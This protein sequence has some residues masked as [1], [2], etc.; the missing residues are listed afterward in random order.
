MKENKDQTKLKLT[1]D[2]D[3]IIKI[4][5]SYIYDIIIPKFQDYIETCKGERYFK[6]GEKIDI[7]KPLKEI[8]KEN[9]SSFQ[10]AENE[11]FIDNQILI[12]YITY[13]KYKGKEINMHNYEKF[14][15]NKDSNAKNI[16]Q[17]LIEFY[18]TK[19]CKIYIDNTI[20]KTT[21]YQLQRYYFNEN[22]MKKK[23]RIHLDIDNKFLNDEKKVKYI[24]EKIVTKISDLTKIPQ[25]E[26]YVTNVRKNCLIFDIYHRIR[27][28][29]G[30]ILRYFVGDI[31]NN[32]IE[33]NQD[34]LKI[35]FNQIYQ[36]IGNEINEIR[37]EDQIQLNRLIKIEGVINNYIKN[38]ELE[39]DSRFNKPIGKFGYRYRFI[40]PDWYEKKK[41]KNGKNYYYPNKKW[42]G[43][44]LR[45]LFKKAYDYIFFPEQIFDSKGNWCICYTDLAFS[46]LSYKIDYLRKDTFSIPSNDTFQRF[47]LLY[48]CKI[49]K[50]AIFEENENVITSY[51][52][53]FLMP[54]R[55]LIENIDANLE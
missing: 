29:V 21:Y 8:I 55:L 40:L 52:E 9:I 25:N 37:D 24:V 45:I 39:F 26:L 3:E 20:D 19:N 33:K 5:S 10:T 46:K 42:E 30:R 15:S 43:Y 41:L 53:H 51:D 35:F 27:K 32:F 31:N 44:G 38:I 13:E 50:Y 7:N 54:Y 49:N 11:E 47:S 14:C 6:V 22:A 23:I 4:I 36:E 17:K 12:D 48:Q 18:K 16:M 2:G 34:E 28:F 1:P